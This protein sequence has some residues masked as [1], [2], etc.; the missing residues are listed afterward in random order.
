M[1]SGLGR[2]DTGSVVSEKIDSLYRGGRR[3]TPTVFQARKA[4]V[5]K[6]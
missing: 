6:N 1:H 3:M 2:N 4:F 5:G